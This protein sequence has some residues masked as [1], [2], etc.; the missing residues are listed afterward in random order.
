MSPQ[1]RVRILGRL[2]YVEALSL[3]RELVRRRA[4]GEIPDTLLLLEHDPV[5]TLGKM[6]RS[7]HV[8]LDPRRLAEMGVE[9]LES[10]RGGDVTYHGPGQVVG[11]P[12]VDL[13]AFRKD[14]KWYVERLEEVMIRTAARFGIQAGRIPGMT[15][16]WVGDQKIGAIGVRVQRWI[17]SHGFAFNVNTDL[18]YF[19]LII[20]C[21]LSGKGVTSLAALLGRS[22]DLEHVQREVA[23]EFG[24]VFGCEVRYESESLRPGLGQSG[25][26]LRARN[27]PG[28]P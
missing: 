21:G 28:T 1:C 26:A 14:V 9:V 7:E 3:Q 15:G 13:S 11:Y 27:A 23:D 6:A 10:D 22:V 18:N 17:A 4:S 20:P 16:A 25:E 2:R 12:I 5:F 8:L 24:R 19:R